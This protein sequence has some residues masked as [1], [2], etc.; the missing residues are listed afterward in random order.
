MSVPFVRRYTWRERG[1]TEELPGL[2]IAHPGRG[3]VFIPWEHAV[4]IADQIID[5]YEEQQQ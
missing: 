2:Q 5:L 4:N 1:T 3:Y